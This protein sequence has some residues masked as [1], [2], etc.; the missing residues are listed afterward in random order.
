MVYPY[1]WASE[2][3]LQSDGGVGR[4]EANKQFAGGRVGLPESII[5]V[6]PNC[7]KPSLNPTHFVSN[8]E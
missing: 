7:I 2:S 3:L 4:A 8:L 6:L 5:F 1:F